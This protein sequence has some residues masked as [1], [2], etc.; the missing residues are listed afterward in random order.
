MTGG[1]YYRAQDANQLKGVFAKLP[2]QVVLQSR[3]VEISAA[4]AAFGALLVAAGAVLSLRWNRT[5]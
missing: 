2:K 5:P 1:A 3:K 4:F